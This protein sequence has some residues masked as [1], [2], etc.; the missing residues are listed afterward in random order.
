MYFSYLNSGRL[1]RQDNSGMWLLE[2]TLNYK[3]IYQHSIYMTTFCSPLIDI[4]LICLPYQQTP[5]RWQDF[6]PHDTDTEP[7]FA[8]PSSFN[9]KDFRIPWSM[10]S[11]GN[12]SF[13]GRTL[14]T[15]KSGFTGDD[16]NVLRQ[17]PRL[18]AHSSNTSETRRSPRDSKAWIYDHLGVPE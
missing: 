7:D 8:F 9:R 11:H 5:Q 13:S 4:L 16:F 3:F 6:P 10:K 2:E 18:P 17:L 1:I 14:Y 15:K 12:N